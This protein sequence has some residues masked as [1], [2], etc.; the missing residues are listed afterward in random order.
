MA[1]TKVEDLQ[2]EQPEASGLFYWV[3]DVNGVKYPRNATPAQIR[4]AL[5]VEAGATADQTGAEI[6]SLYEAEANKN[7]FTDAEKAK[8]AGLDASL[9]LGVYVNLTALQLAHASPATGSYAYVD[10]G[11]S[12]DIS[13]YIWDATDGQYVQQASG[14]TETNASVKTKYEANPD[15]NAFTDQEKSK[16]GAVEDGATADQTPAEIVAAVDGVVGTDWKNV[17]KSSIAAVDPTVTDD[18]N[19]GYSV[20]S[21]WF[22]SV[23]KK[24]FRCNV[25]TAGAAEWVEVLDGGSGNN[26]TAK[27][28]PVSAE[29]MILLDSE[30]GFLPVETTITE[31][32]AA[33]NLKPVLSMTQA[34]Y[35]A[36]GSKD[37]NIV[38]AIT[39]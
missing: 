19:S 33:M 18:T 10:A 3:K 17:A 20:N 29:K 5:G 35:D 16:L 32:L 13:I 21:R 9:F 34:A 11:A 30:N 6:A 24:E 27:A 39:G 4:A 37:P 14:G 23:S 15:T 8:L 7:A 2:N 12:Q 28:V 36:L 38:Y 31:F 26:L 22:N 1:D 25:A